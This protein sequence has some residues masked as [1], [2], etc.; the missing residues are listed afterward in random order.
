MRMSLPCDDRGEE[1]ATRVARAPSSRRPARHPGSHTRRRGR[2]RRSGGSRARPR[3]AR[4][5]SSGGSAPGASSAGTARG[6]SPRPRPR[7]TRRS[8][9]DRCRPCDP[10]RSAASA[11]R[12]RPSSAHRLRANTGTIRP[13]CR[14][15]RSTTETRGPDADAYARC[16]GSSTAARAATDASRNGTNPCS[17]TF[18]RSAS[19][20]GL[21][22]AA[23]AISVASL[24]DRRPARTAASVA[25]RASSFFAVATAERTSPVPTPSSRAP[26]RSRCR[27]WSRRPGARPYPTSRRPPDG[28]HPTGR[29]LASPLRAKARSRRSRRQPS[30]TCCERYQAIRTC[31]RIVADTSTREQ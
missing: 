5:P 6:R 17:T 4:S 29:R 11:S 24:D 28:S 10:G 27:H 1:R 3:R 20:S 21:I 13:T 14:H 12:S 25:G 19:A 26:Q 18:R 23:S 2:A 22:V 30:S 16:F 9:R 8:T 31:V 15:G 7:H